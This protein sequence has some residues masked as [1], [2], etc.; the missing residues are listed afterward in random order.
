MFQGFFAFDKRISVDI[1]AILTK[2][3]KLK[4]KSYIAKLW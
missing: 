4:S 2:R 1:S 3:L